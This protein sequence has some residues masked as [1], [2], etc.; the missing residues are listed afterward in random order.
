MKII[1][2]VCLCLVACGGATATVPQLK[3]NEAPVGSKDAEPADVREDLAY[4]AS[5]DRIQ[6]R[7]LREKSILEKDLTEGDVK[8]FQ[9]DLQEFCAIDVLLDTRSVFHRKPYCPQDP[10]TKQ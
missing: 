1:S 5:L 4:H 6:D 2:I 10:T 9:N 3:A 7:M 8:T